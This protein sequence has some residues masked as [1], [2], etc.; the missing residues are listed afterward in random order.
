MNRHDADSSID[1]QSAASTGSEGTGPPGQSS[2]WVGG[3]A[4]SDSTAAPTSPRVVYVPRFLYP[5][6][7]RTLFRGRIVYATFYRSRVR[8][9]LRRV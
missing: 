9:G 1:H 7:K 8:V 3:P 6:L 4:P 5:L 2:C